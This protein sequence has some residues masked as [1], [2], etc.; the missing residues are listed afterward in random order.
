MFDF[1]FCFFSV[2]GELS[3]KRIVAQGFLET[4]VLST[5]FSHRGKFHV[6]RQILCPAEAR[7]AAT[8]FTGQL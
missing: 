5:L 6:P 2:L 1:Q 7:Q 3:Q 4:D 8:V